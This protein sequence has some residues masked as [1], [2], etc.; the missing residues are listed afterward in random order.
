[1][2]SAK[3]RLYEHATGR[4]LAGQ[5]SVDL[6]WIELVGYLWQRGAFPRARG[7]WLGWRFGQCGARPLIGRRVRLLF[8]G[9]LHAGDRLFI[10]DDSYI[11]AYAVNGIRLGHD[12]RIREG[13][14]IQATSQLDQPGVGLLVGDGT[15]IGPRCL[16]GAGGGITI[17]RGVTFG[18]GVHLLAENHEFRDAARTIQDQGVTRAGITIGDD[19]WIGNNVIVLDGVRVG[20]GAVIGAGA[21]VTKDVPECAI[22][23]GNPARVVGARGGAPA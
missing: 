1:M 17:G 6:S 23:V 8:P 16:L 15:Y 19:V 21:V 10:G 3:R 13:A 14:W 18:A 22:A 5:R 2:S 12:V 9:H 7:F 4:T 11:S 20:K